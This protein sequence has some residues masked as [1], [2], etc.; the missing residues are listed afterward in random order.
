MNV[1]VLFLRQFPRMDICRWNVISANESISFRWIIIVMI[2]MATIILCLTSESFDERLH[3]LTN[4][5]NSNQSA[6]MAIRQMV[7]F[8]KCVSSFF[9]IDISRFHD[10]FDSIPQEN[11]RVLSMW[12]SLSVAQS[13]GAILGWLLIGL[14]PTEDQLYEKLLEMEKYRVG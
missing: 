3:V 11:N 8:S 7:R 9:I 5:I 10:I 4:H 13:I 6:T 12:S 1:V 14:R 2:Y